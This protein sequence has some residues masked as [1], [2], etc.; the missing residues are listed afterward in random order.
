MFRSFLDKRGFPG[1]WLVVSACLLVCPATGCDEGSRD[2]ECSDEVDNDRD[3]LLD[4]YDPDCEGM[5][6]CECRDH[7]TFMGEYI[8]AYCDALEACGYLT[9]YYGYDDCMAS[10]DL[11]NCED[12]DCHATGGCI[13]ATETV[14]CGDLMDSDWSRPCRLVCSNW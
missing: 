6:G 10:A 12:Y 7:E 9:V 2:G 8:T 5:P 4:C 3:G 1:P 14:S 13:D 11:L